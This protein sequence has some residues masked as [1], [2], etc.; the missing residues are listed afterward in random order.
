ML[1]T[2]IISIGGY[3]REEPSKQVVHKTTV[4]VTKQVEKKKISHKKKQEMCTATLIEEPKQAQVTSG[5]SASSFRQQGVIHHNGHRFTWYSE[6][7]LPG[8]GLN[9]PGRHVNASGYVCDVN[10]YVAV[11]SCD[12]AQGT[13]VDTP[14]GIQGKVYDICPSSGTIDVYVSW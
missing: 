14:L 13:V 8:G 3:N 4:K 7:V 12:Y 10:G 6:K 5:V 11:A 1:I 9:I 2:G